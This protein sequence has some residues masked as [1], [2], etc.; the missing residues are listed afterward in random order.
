MLGQ[1]DFV[2]TFPNQHRNKYDFAV[3]AGLINNNYLDDKI[4]NQ[5][6]ISVKNGGYLVFAA[7]YSY[8]GD[9][10]YSTCLMNLEK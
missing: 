7:R 5:M 9:Y 1:Q 2:N 8:L 10:W 3:A 4:F 6:L